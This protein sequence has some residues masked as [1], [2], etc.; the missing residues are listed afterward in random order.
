MLLPV[1][2]FLWFEYH[3]RKRSTMNKTEEKTHD[4]KKT[5]VERE[6]PSRLLL[7]ARDLIEHN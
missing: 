4:M 1:V 7:I 5:T 2:C 3:S 6:E